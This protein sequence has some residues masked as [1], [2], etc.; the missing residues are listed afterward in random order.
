MLKNDSSPTKGIQVARYY[1]GSITTGRREDLVAHGY[2]QDGPF[3]GD[4]G[5]N[6]YS[7]KS[8]DP[9][10][11][12]ISLKR[13]SKHLFA[14][15]RDWSD[16]EAAAYR[17]AEDKRRAHQQEIERATRLV[18]SWPASADKFRADAAIFVKG[19]MD[20][21]ERMLDSGQAGGYRLYDTD[22][23]QV[24]ELSDRLRKLVQSGGIVWDPELR[25]QHIPAC[26]AVEIQ[27]SAAAAAES[28]AP[29]RV[30]NVIQFR[31][32]GRQN[33][34]DGEFQHG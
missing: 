17:V 25:K 9:E 12:P 11:R 10:G 6:K 2:A 33:K 14:V 7:A 13:K 16:E 19:F 20:A 3:P 30:D 34:T 24:Y 21:I 23:E 18:A 15:W 8:E 27:D 28:C 31:L 5:A 32:P 26:I 22:I 4:P 29:L 1:W